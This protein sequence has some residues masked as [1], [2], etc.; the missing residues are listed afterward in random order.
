MA[1]M[2]MATPR[3][4]F[5]LL[6]SCVLGAACGALLACGTPLD[7]L[8]L[9]ALCEDSDDCAPGQECVRTAYQMVA[10]GQGWCRDNDSCSRGTQPGCAC[11]QD[12]VTFS[13]MNSSE[14]GVVAS[15]NDS[16]CTCLYQCTTGSGG[17]D[18]CPQGLVA[19]EPEMPTA[20][21]CYCVPQ[22]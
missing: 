3:R 1:R 18:L 22:G 7:E 16:T 5:I 6:A 4:H 21:S 20:A 15:T 10:G 8:L 2:F 12:G 13:C 19:F 14:S 17:V 11:D 9:D